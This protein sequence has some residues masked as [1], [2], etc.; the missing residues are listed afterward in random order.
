MPKFP[1]LTPKKLISFLKNQG[2]VEDHTSGSHI[3]F[4]NPITKRR[5]VVPFHKKDLPK[6]TLF[7]ILKEAGFSKKDYLQ[8][9]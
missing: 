8:S 2:F 7:S 1:S 9:K 6:G 3:V 5:A 4:Y